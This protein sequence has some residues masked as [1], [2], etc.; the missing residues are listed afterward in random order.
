VPVPE[1]P[2]AGGDAGPWSNARRSGIRF[3]FFI[4]CVCVC[5]WV[6]GS[7]GGLSFLSY[8]PPFIGG[9]NP[10]RVCACF[11]GVRVFFDY[12]WM[13]GWMCWMDVLASQCAE[14]DRSDGR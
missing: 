10:T 5:V 3:Y 13:D 2:S 7:L 1:I 11:L 4:L 9:P 6:G 12:G 14:Y 8:E